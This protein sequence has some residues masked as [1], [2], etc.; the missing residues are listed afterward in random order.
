M[1]VRQLTRM[2]RHRRSFRFMGVMWA[3]FGGVMAISFIPIALDPSAAFNYNGAPTAALGAKLWAIVFA[4]LF[5]VAGLCMVFLPVRML[6]RFI[7]WELSA[8]SLLAFWK[9]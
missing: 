9:R 3:L 5:F 6:D 4:A 1:D 7:L 2:R 8:W